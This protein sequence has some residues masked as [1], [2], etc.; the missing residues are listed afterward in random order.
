VKGERNRPRHCGGSVLCQRGR[1]LQRQ[2]GGSKVFGLDKMMSST[3]EQDP[4]L[5]VQAL[6]LP[7]FLTAPFPSLPESFEPPPQLRRA[8]TGPATPFPPIA[9]KLTPHQ[10]SPH[11]PHPNPRPL[12]LL[13]PDPLPF[14]LAPQPR[15][16]LRPR[17]T[18]H[19]PHLPHR[20]PL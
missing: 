4:F 11:L 19:L 13:P 7:H 17:R 2:Y 15:A 12:H 8:S 5:Q 6:V 10:R 18:N 20:R 14:P 3:N 9:T 16:N 1:S